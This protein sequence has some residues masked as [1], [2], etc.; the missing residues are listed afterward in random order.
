MLQIFLLI[1]AEILAPVIIG[2]KNGCLKLRKNENPE[3]L[4]VC[5]VIHGENLVFKNISPVLIEVLKSVIK[6][7][8]AIKVNAKCESFFKN[9][10]KI[11]MQTM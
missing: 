9:F 8:N 5:T 10:V 6:C 11:K 3:M 7:I 1:L 4:L 2:K